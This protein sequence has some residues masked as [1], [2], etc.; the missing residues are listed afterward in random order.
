LKDIKSIE[1][2][3]FD[4]KSEPEFQILAITIFKYQYETN[5]IYKSFVDSLKI[6]VN[7]VKD[8]KHIPFLPIE[9]FKSKKVICGNLNSDF[10]CF[11]SSGTTGQITSKHYVN[12]ISLYE[13]SFSK[14][15]TLFYGDIKEYCILALLPSY[16]E[17]GGSS[18]VYMA[19]QLIK[20]S[21]HPLSGFYLHNLDDLVNT[22]SVL[23]KRNQKTIL[24]G[25][26]YALLDLAEKNI[27]LNEH[28]IVM[29][30]G[31]MKGKREELTK[32]ELHQTLKNK[33][34]IKTIQS[35]Y[36]MTELL[37][38]SYALSNGI[39]K[40]VPWKRILIRDISDPFSYVLVGKTGGVNV[41]DLAN[42]HS[43]SFIETKDLGKYYADH[44]F[45]IV[46]R[47]DASDLRGCNLL[48]Q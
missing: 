32:G 41:I 29:E 33:F 35:E 4:I 10:V 18:L 42:L 43:C 45:E 22:I 1:K 13:D 11:S 47:F 15:F 19:N 23:K 38:Q 6:N 21:G 7:E 8:F 30:T 46:G 40:S 25:V 5:L 28:F 37:S 9:F 39:F 20:D 27:I 17:K 14:G 24:L 36:G 3:I 12:S 2:K 48:I 44:S 26:S 34:K 16:L 31:G